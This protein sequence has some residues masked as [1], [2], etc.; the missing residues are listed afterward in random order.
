[1]RG[2]GL[3]LFGAGG[4]GGRGLPL[5]KQVSANALSVTTCC[6]V[7][8]VGGIPDGAARGVHFLGKP[9]SVAVRHVVPDGVADDVSI[10]QRLVQP[11]LP[12]AQVRR[13]VAI[14][15][16]LV[17][18]RVCRARFPGAVCGAGV[19]G[20][21]VQIVR[22]FSNHLTFNGRGHGLVPVVELVVRL[23]PHLL[24]RV[25]RHKH[26]LCNFVRRKG[27][28]VHSNVCDVPLV[29]H[30]V[31]HMGPDGEVARRPRIL[32]DDVAD[33]LHLALAVQREHG[34]LHS[35]VVE[36]AHVRRKV[37]LLLAV[38]IQRELPGG[39]DGEHGKVPLLMAEQRILVVLIGH[40]GGVG[41]PRFKHQAVVHA[42][43]HARSVQLSQ[44][45]LG[46]WYPRQLGHH[47]PVGHNLPG[48]GVSE[49]C[50]RHGHLKV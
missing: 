36:V 15:V 13:H 11:E 1:M 40:H 27:A 37:R 19:A 42:E 47:G 10:V 21:S 31:V 23:Q 17:R 29:F 41:N 45:L 39:L 20:T 25:Q 8:F 3:Q 6:V 46:V 48:H 12:L 43:V 2:D 5:E 28:R 22:P 26:L 16:V 24:V 32:G 18:V 7:A 30:R 50:E 34:L 35:H 49:R 38:Q 33:D 44:A 14:D 9:G 4:H